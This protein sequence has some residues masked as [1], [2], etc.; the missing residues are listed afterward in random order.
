M[1]RLDL[2]RLLRG[3]QRRAVEDV[4]AILPQPCRIDDANGKTLVGAADGGAPHPIVASGDEIGVAVG[5]E[6]AEQIARLVAH[7]FGREQ[8]KLALAAETLGRYKELTVL[9]DMSAG[10]SRV[11]DVR[12][13]ASMVV[14]E[15]KRFLGASEAAILLLDSRG[16]H[17]EPIAGGVEEL[18]PRTGVEARVIASARAELIEER[19][20]EEGGGSLVCA[21]LRSGEHVFGLFRVA[22]SEKA[23]WNAGDLKLVTS[24][25]ANAAAAI[26]HAML[27]RDQLRQ[28]ALRNRIERFVSP[29]LVEIAL[30]NHARTE[31]GPA[32]IA[33]L[34]CDVSDLARTLDPDLS[35]DAV[36][37]SM[38]GATSVAMEVLLAHDASVSIA[39]GEMI[40]ALFGTAEGFEASVGAAVEAARALVHRLDRRFGGILARSPGIGIAR[41]EDADGFFSGVGV[42]AT[43]QSGAEGRILV[44]RAV[45]AVVSRALASQPPPP[46]G[47]TPDVAARPI[48][49]H[50][51]RA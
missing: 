25:A 15:A 35:D 51:V 5:G 3:Q 11:L 30:E 10:L 47:S 45:G 32:P 16:E 37:E 27:H 33:V 13:V 44:D 23:R 46:P 28:Q 8:E 39:Q 2:K 49:A 31:S 20:E 6:G 43:L 22:S 48:E 21:P 9:Y 34:V 40:V 12:E 7:L 24:L 26:S 1:P 36:L 50:E 42:A 29:A 14:G 38:L 41:V 18:D 19:P 17:L 4:L